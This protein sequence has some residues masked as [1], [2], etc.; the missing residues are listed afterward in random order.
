MWFT[1]GKSQELECGPSGVRGVSRVGNT[2]TVSDTWLRCWRSAKID[3]ALIGSLTRAWPL[4]TTWGVRAA[5][6]KCAW[7]LSMSGCTHVFAVGFLNYGRSWPVSGSWGG[8][9]RPLHPPASGGGGPA[10][11]GSSGRCSSGNGRVQRRNSSSTPGAGK[12][13]QNKNLIKKQK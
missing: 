1:S 13:R 12:N 10:G 7:D 5:V 9:S 6:N 4:F 11:R 2:V 8:A 3:G